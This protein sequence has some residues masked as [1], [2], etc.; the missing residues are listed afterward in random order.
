[1]T[2]RCILAFGF[3]MLAATLTPSGVV[4]AQE[5]GSAARNGAWLGER[6]P[7]SSPKLFARGFVST[8]MYERDTA[9]MPDGREIYW[10]VLAPV[11]QRGT[12]VASRMRADGSWSKPFV[13]VIF[14][15][16]SN[17]EPFITADGRWLWFA[18]NRPLPGES[19]S[20]DW[21]L[22]RAPREDDHWGAPRALPAPINLDGDEFYPS[23]TRDGTV[24]FTAERAGLERRGESGY[25][26]QHRGPR[27]QRSRPAGWRLDSLW[28]I[29]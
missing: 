4:V 29:A 7:G 16:S 18:S 25:G 21:N 27:V 20:G 22:W 15:G 26:R 5:S 8:G 2:P 9:W 24:Y 1:M 10:T 23:L 3:T 17:L 19:E 6:P 14:Q 13:P 28:L 11:S 12:I